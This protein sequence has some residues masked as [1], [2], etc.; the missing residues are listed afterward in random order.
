ML[1]LLC[2][3]NNNLSAEMKT[4]DFCMRRWFSHKNAKQRLVKIGQRARVVVSDGGV[5][6]CFTSRPSGF[7]EN[8]KLVSP[9]DWSRWGRRLAW[10]LHAHLSG[11]HLPPLPLLI[12]TVVRLSSG[13][14]P[15]LIN[16]QTFPPG[17]MALY[18]NNTV[19]MATVRTAFCSSCSRLSPLCLAV[20]RASFSLL[21]ICRWD[22]D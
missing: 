15:V 21:E 13:Q 7:L 22:W 6:F 17:V 19:I 16:L 18:C 11:Q 5:F 4:A 8:R 3:N 12:W 9:L 14:S 2:N 1:L 20:F 10:R